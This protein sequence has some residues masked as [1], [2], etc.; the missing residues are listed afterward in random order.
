MDEIPYEDQSFGIYVGMLFMRC[1]R[2]AF[3]VVCSFVGCNFCFRCMSLFVTTQI[4][5]SKTCKYQS[6]D[7]QDH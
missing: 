5:N 7:H 6:Q 1:C 4:R 2:M 3:T